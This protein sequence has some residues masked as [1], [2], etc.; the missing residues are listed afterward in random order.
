[1]LSEPQANRQPNRIGRKSDGRIKI[2]FQTCS[3]PL[4]TQRKTGSPLRRKLYVPALVLFIVYLLLLFKLLFF[5]LTVNFSDIAITGNHNSSFKTLWAGSNF[6]PFYR[7]WYY[8]S[9][10]EPY[11]VGALNIFGNVLL[12]VPLGAA[13]PFFFKRIN[14]LRRLVLF[15]FLFALLIEAMQLLTATGEFDID[16]ALLNTLGAVVGYAFFVRI[17]KPL[18][19]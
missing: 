11:L 16:D 3:V 4:F 2:N 14:S 7:I 5:K 15:V 1:M 13:L 6:V 17:I 19:A 8:A 12:F 9:G 18:L 10:Q